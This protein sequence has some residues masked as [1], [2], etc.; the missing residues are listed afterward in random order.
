MELLLNLVWLM[1]ALPALL[2]SRRARRAAEDSGQVC[3]TNSFVLVGCLLLLLFPVISATDDLLALRF[4]MEES[5]A[6]KRLVK[7]SA[8]PK[9]LMSG[10]DDGTSV[11][12][13]N[14]AFYAPDNELCNAPSLYAAILPQ[15]DAASTIGC[16]APPCPLCP[17]SSVS[18]A[19]SKAARFIMF[20]LDFRLPSQPA[21]TTGL[22]PGRGKR[23]RRRTDYGAS[24]AKHIF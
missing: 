21:L 6:T 10:N 16:R 14:V 1:L 24:N 8:G 7:Q 18:T 2:L 15:Y 11:K 19:P 13:Q 12:L 3:R 17:E 9:V 4:E 5:S 23:M 20:K 22:R